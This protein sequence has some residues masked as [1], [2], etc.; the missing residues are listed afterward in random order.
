MYRRRKLIL[1]S[2]LIF[3]SSGCALFDRTDG[4]QE[5]DTIDSSEDAVLQAAS[6]QRVARDFVSVL[7]RL[8]GYGPA[9]RTVRF[10]SERLWEDSL[11]RALEHRMRIVGYS[12]KVVDSA[13]GLSGVAHEIERGDGGGDDT[14]THTISVDDVQLRRSYLQVPGLAWEPAG[15]LYV[16]GADASGIRLEESDSQQ[17]VNEAEPLGKPLRKDG[18]TLDEDPVAVP[19]PVPRRAPLIAEQLTNPLLPTAPVAG[20]REEAA[21]VEDEAAHVSDQ[22]ALMNDDAAVR[23][24]AFR[25]PGFESPPEA[26]AEHAAAGRDTSNRVTAKR[27]NRQV[28]SPDIDVTDGQPIYSGIV[29]GQTAAIAPNRL[30]RNMMDLG[31]SNFSD[32]FEAYVNVDEVVMIFPNDS[33]TMGAVNK[34]LIHDTLQQFD[35][36]RDLFAIVGC[37]LGK[38]ALKN[39]NEAL[40]LGRASRVREELLFSGVPSDRILDEGCWAGE[41]TVK[42]PSRG[43]VLTHK[44]LAG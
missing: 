30:S 41:A 7:T 2:I 1:S 29:P 18:T 9:A 14:I 28:T 11:L 42:F 26:P 16:R 38:T 19:K 39:G 12:V 32:T 37:S 40:A 13:S 36:E 27:D 35:P 22:A 5:H 3:A 31:D 10:V 4:G 23:P 17:R 34:A 43:V 24:T 21:F 25:V 44:R 15:S 8:D 6:E 20:T 33:L